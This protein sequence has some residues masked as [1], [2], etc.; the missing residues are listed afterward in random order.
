MRALLALMILSLFGSYASAQVDV[1]EE[2]P[3]VELSPAAQKMV[4]SWKLNV[5]KSKEHMPAE[6]FEM[7]KEMTKEGGVT[8]IFGTD[9]KYSLQ[10]AGV[11]REEERDYTVTAVEDA[12]E[13]HY[14]I[15][16]D[17]ERRMLEAKAYFVDENTIKFVP[18]DEDP[19]IMD[20][21]VEEEPEADE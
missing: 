10:V 4:G 7:M 18:E 14:V 3:A 21:V 19:V 6:V 9:G 12:E 8:M 5:D 20:R 16:V 13:P 15:T 17:S 1:Q 2:P 11:L